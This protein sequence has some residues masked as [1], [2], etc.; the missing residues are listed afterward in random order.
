MVKLE[1]YL[2][3]AGELADLYYEDVAV[4]ITD[5]EKILAY[6]PG[7]TLDFPMKV[8]DKTRKGAI[9]EEAMR[10]GTRVVRRVS[11]ELLGIASVGVGNPIVKKCIHFCGQKIKGACDCTL[12]LLRLFSAQNVYCF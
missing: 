9:S 10:T 11:K 8:G 1:T 6:Y 4:T 3:I 12:F 7:K 2:T 5:T